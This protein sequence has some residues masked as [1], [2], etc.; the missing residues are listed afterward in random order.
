VKRFGLAAVVRIREADA[1]QV[2][3]AAC[4][5][6]EEAREAGERAAALEAR[7]G[8]PGAGSPGGAIDAS[9]C[10]TSPPH[11]LRRLARALAE[12]ARWRDRLERARRRRAGEAAVARGVADVLGAVAARAA[13]DALCARR[14]AD[15]LGRAES[16]FREALRRER[17]A[18]EE[19]EGEEA[20]GARSRER[21]A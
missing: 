4:Q 5:A 6:G 10:G 2:A 19:R 17:E 7:V 9:G 13:E 18:R 8:P 16:R 12:D 15:A 20:W 14:R 11:S 3:R 1:R 21:P